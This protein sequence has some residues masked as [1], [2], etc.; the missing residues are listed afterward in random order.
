MN[1]IYYRLGLRLLLGVAALAIGH[2]PAKACG[3]LFCDSPPPNPFAP[4]PIAQS[5]ENIVFGVTTD[6]KTGVQT[7]QAHIQIFYSG[8]AAK[9]SWI[10]PVDAAPTVGVGTD[11][12]FTAVAGVTQPSYQYD[13]SVEGTCK[14]EPPVNNAGGFAAGSGGS[15]ASAD[16][17]VAPGGGVQVISM[18]SVGPY[19][20]A[21]IH[22]TDRTSAELVQWLTDNGYYVGADAVSI[23]NEY[24]LENKYFVAVRLQNGQN[25]QSIQPVV[26]TFSNADPCVPLRLTAIAAL[27]NLRVNLWVLGDSRA[28]PKNY[29]ELTVNETKIN[30]Q[31]GGY[32]YAQL[33]QE[34]ADEAGGNAF[35]AEYAGT[36]RILDKALWPN[37][38]IDL[39]ALRNATDPP[40]YLQQLITQGLTGTPQLLALLE[41][42]IPEPQSLKDMGVPEL[43][44]YSNNFT[45]WS[46]YKSAFAPFDSN[47]LTDAIDTAIMAPLRD[48][49]ALF[50]AHPYLTRLATYISPIEMTSD[51]IFI[52]NPDLPNLSNQHRAVAHVMCG[53][54]AYLYCDAPVQ[55]VLPGG[56]SIWY[57]HFCASGDPSDDLLQ[58]P[59]LDVAYQRAEGGEGNHVADNAALI[60]QNLT[61]HNRAVAAALALP[62]S[63]LMP[64]GTPATPVGG[65]MPGATTAGGGGGCACNVGDAPA[66]SA[67]ALALLLGLALARTRRQR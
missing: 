43:Q 31:A 25:V 7:V 20:T 40:S 29:F 58:G 53:N 32:N 19:D 15:S 42:F 55:W 44:F 62:P 4:L 34:A 6:P 56:E 60:E 59:S 9:F 39:A 33:V 12:M 8:P 10:V 41:K 63:A 22:S 23:I 11:Q 27:D 17:A 1:R 49:Q 3:G 61:K 5:G 16:A 46:Q 13:T 51:P 26:L 64:D 50:D 67:A 18:G 30:W 66:G 45:Y 35:I 2:R 52:F 54:Q 21:V 38:R 48:G 47:M 28:V 65:V 14:P 57:Q 37:P 36:A 24:V